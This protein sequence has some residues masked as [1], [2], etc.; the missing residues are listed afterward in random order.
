MRWLGIIPQAKSSALAAPYKL[1]SQTL[2]D[3]PWNLRLLDRKIHFEMSQRLKGLIAHLI[4]MAHK[5]VD[6]LKKRDTSE[7]IEE[8]GRG[9][10]SKYEEDH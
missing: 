10:E 6:H 1:S 5:K 7:E 8:E 2:V 4:N 9:I 3:S